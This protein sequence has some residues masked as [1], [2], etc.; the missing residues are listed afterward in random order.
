MS[1]REEPSRRVGIRLPHVVESLESNKPAAD[2]ASEKRFMQAAI[3]AQIA[4]DEADLRNPLRGIYSP[5][6]GGIDDLAELVARA[7]Q[8]LQPSALLAP[9]SASS[10][11]ATDHAGPRAE[12][13]AAPST[14]R[15]RKVGEA[16]EGL[17]C[18]AVLRAE[19]AALKAKRCRQTTAALAEKYGCS[20]DTIRKHM[21]KGRPVA[22]V[23]KQ[24]RR[25]A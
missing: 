25:A 20:S 11:A 5:P 1:N 12:C 14:P 18:P 23:Y 22:S 3:A 7:A 19:Q 9:A 10:I 17:P 8:R 6:D 16:V 4:A 15:T 13:A 2:A 24:G 21:D